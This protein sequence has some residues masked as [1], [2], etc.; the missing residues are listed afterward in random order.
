MNMHADFELFKKNNIV[1]EEE[2]WRIGVWH[3]LFFGYGPHTTAPPEHQFIVLATR[4]P[5]FG[6]LMNLS[7]SMTFGLSETRGDIGVYCGHKKIKQN[8]VLLSSDP[9]DGMYNQFKDNILESFKLVDKDGTPEYEKLEDSVAVYKSENCFL[10]LFT[11]KESRDVFMWFLASTRKLGFPEM[12]I[13]DE[14]T[15]EF[16]ER[17]GCNIIPKANRVDYADS[18]EV[19]ELYKTILNA[20]I[21]IE[22]GQRE[23]YDKKEPGGMWRSYVPF[24]LYSQDV[25]TP[26]RYDYTPAGFPMKSL[27]ERRGIDVGLLAGCCQKLTPPFSVSVPWC[28]N[29]NCCT[30]EL[31]LSD[32]VGLT[33]FVSGQYDDGGANAP[34]VVSRLPR[35]WNFLEPKREKVIYRPK[36]IELDKRRA[37]PSAARWGLWLVK[38]HVCGICGEEIKE[39]DDC[40]VDHI[41]PWSKGGRTIPENAQLTH[42]KCNMSKGNR[43]D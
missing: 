11:T 3:T 42:A 34:F 22:D 8:F 33:L 24:R 4:L 13:C 23:D 37:F 43:E 5:S 16:F 36:P 27:V 32:S 10:W 38:P 25:S 40:Q 35:L 20:P 15:I 28:D 29:N 17:R 31:V 14:E 26:L 2:K 19:R 12:F 9:E 30:R 6:F 18:E 39:F 21:T 7:D 41:I 1:R